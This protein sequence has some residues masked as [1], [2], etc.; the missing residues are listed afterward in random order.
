M[1]QSHGINLLQPSVCAGELLCIVLV[2]IANLAVFLSI[3]CGGMVETETLSSCLCLCLCSGVSYIAPH[4]NNL[5][6]LSLCR[7]CGVYAV[8]RG[9]FFLKLALSVVML[10]AGPDQVY[11]L[12]I[13]IAR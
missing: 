1:P 10:L 4:L 8:V 5:Y 6:F 3:M 2:A 9:L 11:L 13:F 7:R 12:C